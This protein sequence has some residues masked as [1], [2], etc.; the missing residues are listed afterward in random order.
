MPHSG[1]STCSPAPDASRR[2]RQGMRLIQ[3]QC[4]LLYARDQLDARC[5][6]HA[7]SSGS[8]CMQSSVVAQQAI[9]SLPTWLMH[10]QH[11]KS[12]QLP[13]GCNDL[14]I[15]GHATIY[16]MAPLVYTS[17]Y[18]GWT[19]V[20]LWLTVLRTCFRVSGAAARC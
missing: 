1:A 16:V 5:C 6:S 15:S 9:G 13:A 17:Y 4:S 7:C 20:L 18:P 8:W 3:L 14:I 2:H 10:A 11:L 19:A 12:V